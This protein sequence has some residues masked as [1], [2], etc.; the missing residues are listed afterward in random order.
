MFCRIPASGYNP[1][2]FLTNGFPS[3]LERLSPQKFPESLPIKFS[4]LCL[5]SDLLNRN[6]PRVQKL[7]PRSLPKV[8]LKF[9]ARKIVTK[10]G[11]LHSALAWPLI[12][13]AVTSFRQPSFVTRRIMMTGRVSFAISP[14]PVPRSRFW[15]Q[16]RHHQDKSCANGRHGLCTHHGRDSGITVSETVSASSG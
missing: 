11:R 4:C 14:R 16:I 13:Q 3:I 10:L 8:S 5:H 9:I 1:I 15:W 2:H 12:P 6:V 7:K